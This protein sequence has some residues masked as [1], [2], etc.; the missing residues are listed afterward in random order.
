L[1]AVADRHAKGLQHGF[2]RGVEQVGDL[3]VG[4]AL[5]EVEAYERHRKLLASGA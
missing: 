2:V 3:F 5:D 4:A 1:V